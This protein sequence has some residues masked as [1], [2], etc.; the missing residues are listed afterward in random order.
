MFEAKI[1]PIGRQPQHPTAHDMRGA[2]NAALV[3]MALRDP[4]PIERAAKLAI[5]KRDGWL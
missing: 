5:L 1:K 3:A 4:C 2:L